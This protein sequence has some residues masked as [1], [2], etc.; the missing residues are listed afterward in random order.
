MFRLGHVYQEEE[1]GAEVINPE[2]AAPAAEQTGNWYDTLPEDMRGDQNITKHSTI[3]GFAKSHQ[4]AQRMIGAEKIPMPQT[5]ED[6]GNVYGRLGR[7]D[8]STGY[9]IEAPEGV[10]VNVEM[11]ESFRGVAH[12]LGLSQKQVQGL[13]EWQFGNEATSRQGQ[14][15]NS[16]QA[17]EAAQAQLK[18]EWGESY[19]QNVT[20]AVRGAS[21]FLSDNDKEFMNTAVIDGVKA[22]EHPVLIKMFNNIAKGMMEPSKLEGFTANL[23]QTPQE[24]QE[25]RESL[26]GNS[27][28]FDKNHP[29][30]KGV[31]RKVS[32]LFA[33][34]FPNS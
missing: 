23:S 19:D 17:H 20:I 30:H 2:T 29:E 14:L 9:A 4:N 25:E 31:V 32:E 21:E 3:E 8:D 5:D 10:E 24:M 26:M 1:V 34:Q 27:A 13:S 12:E 7:P 18:Q 22:G 6:W 28:Y 33:K 11:Q 15:D 16:T